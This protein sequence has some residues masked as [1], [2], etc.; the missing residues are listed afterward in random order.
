MSDTDTK[1]ALVSAYEIDAA[2]IV[3]LQTELAATQERARETLEA[4]LVYGKGPYTVNGKDVVVLRRKGT[5]C[6]MP[7]VRV[8]KSKRNTDASDNVVSDDTV[9]RD[10][11]AYVN[12]A[13]EDLAISDDSAEA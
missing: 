4:L 1:S 13:S 5:M 9:E 6:T 10:A 2:N 12:E 3:R 8:R 11:A 7:A